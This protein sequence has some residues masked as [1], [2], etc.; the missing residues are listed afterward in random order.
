MQGAASSKRKAPAPPSKEKFVHKWLLSSLKGHAGPVSDM[1]FSENGK[2]LISCADDD[3]VLIWST[4]DFE[5]KEHKAHRGNVAFDTAARVKWS[6]D[7]RAYII[8]KARANVAEVYKINRKDGGGGGLGPV[9]SVVTFPSRHD[10]DMAGLGFASTGRFVMTCSD[11]TTLI[12]WSIRGDVLAT[13]DTYQMQTFCAKVSPCGRYVA[14]SGFTPDVKVW[15]VKF[16]RAGEFEHARVAFTL[17]GHSSGIYHFDFNPD[18]SR[19]ATLSKDNTW[20]LFATDVEFEKGQEPS[21]LLKVSFANP[22]PKSLIR[23]S[24]DS[25]LVSIGHK[26]EV[27]LFSA[28]NGEPLG[29][30]RDPHSGCP[31]SCMVFDKEGRWLL[32]SGDKHIRIF[33]NVP[34]YLRRKQ[35]LKEKLIGAK[36]ESLRERLQQQIDEIEIK[37]AE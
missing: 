6:P 31:I 26:C 27:S 2:Y 20:R 4:K 37:L 36:S 9:E 5:R 29:V 25:E 15:E 11:K 30:I 7:S 1:D 34:G 28:S 10:T 19:M 17:G 3:A 22:E 32:T 8:Q 35:V 33:K 23:L 24:A 13:L 21:E 16:S 14:S 18:S 12:V